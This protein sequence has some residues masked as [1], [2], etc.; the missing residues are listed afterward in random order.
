MS[1]V[2]DGIRV[3]DFGR[4]IA[5]PYCA[6]LLGDLGAEVI[7]IERVGGGD[8]RFVLPLAG[9]E[10]GAMFLPLNRNKKSVTLD[11]ATAEGKEIVRKLVA[12]A[13]VVVVNLPPQ[14]LASLELDYDSL[15]AIKPDIILTSLNAFGSKGPWSHKVGLDGIAQAM[16]GL[17]H[18]TGE[19]G[20]PMKAYGPW[21]DFA[22]ATMGAFGTMAALLWRKQTGQGQHVEGSLLSSALVPAA[23]LIA[24]QGVCNANRGPTA[25]R[26][27]TGA[28]ADMFKTKDGWIIVQVVGQ[29]LF[30]RWSRLIGEDSWLADDRFKDDASRAIHGEVLSERMA[31]WCIER[32]NA[33]ALAEL[34]K[35][36]LPAGPVLTPQ[37]IL[38]HEHVKAAE[39]FK[40]V[41][42]PGLPKP[43]PMLGTPVSL[44]E[45]PG[46]IRSRPPTIGQHTD[47]ILASLGYKAGEVENLRRGGIV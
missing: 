19:P 31:R 41:E 6:C 35:A 40:F 45:T 2:L 4:Y 13:D 33:E 9:E 44:S 36:S 23:A 32:T 20:N 30:K 37:E 12:T 24:E 15:K 42:Y 21:A 5:G 11:P 43:T 1:G 46:E 38:D 17:C 10:G 3:L 26:S 29:P 16:S 34:D 27:Q 22:T 7:R 28:P 18:M 14:A 25:N 8:D 39:T 47:A